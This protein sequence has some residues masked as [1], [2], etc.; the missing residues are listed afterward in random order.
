MS[1]DLSLKLH[2]LE[3]IQI[4]K[5]KKAME[6]EKKDLG[7]TVKEKVPKKGQQRI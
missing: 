4:P 5:G 7:N 1:L 6:V 3:Q 2:V